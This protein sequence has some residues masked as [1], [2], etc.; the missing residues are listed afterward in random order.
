MNIDLTPP[1][2]VPFVVAGGIIAW[3]VGGAIRRAWDEWRARVEARKSAA[4]PDSA[5]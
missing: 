1:N 2:H 4:S 5:Q 3:Y